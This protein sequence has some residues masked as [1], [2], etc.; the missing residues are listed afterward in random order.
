MPQ[1]IDH[2]QVSHPS[3]I[4]TLWEF[5][6]VCIDVRS[7]SFFTTPMAFHTGASEPAEKRSA[8]V[9]YS[10]LTT[11]KYMIYGHY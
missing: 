7:S 6:G 3:A 9:P 11:I 4:V 2:R 10:L 5:L 8:G 1:I